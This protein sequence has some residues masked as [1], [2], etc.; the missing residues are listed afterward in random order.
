VSRKRKPSVGPAPDC[1]AAVNHPDWSK[2]VVDL[3]GP[4]EVEAP[5]VWREVKRVLSLPIRVSLSR[6]GG[7]ADAGGITLGWASVAPMSM[8]ARS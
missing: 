7:S 1:V 4:I 6:V 2:K 3:D 8:T 5:F